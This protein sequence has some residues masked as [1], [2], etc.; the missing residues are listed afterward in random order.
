MYPVTCG[1]VFC[2]QGVSQRIGIITGPH[3]AQN[4]GSIFLGHFT[5]VGLGGVDL[6]PPILRMFLQSG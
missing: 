6:P 4:A 2:V 5:P 3:A 1:F